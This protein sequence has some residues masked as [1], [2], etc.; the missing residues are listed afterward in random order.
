MQ[1]PII[2][3]VLTVPLDDLTD[4]ETHVQAWECGGE[5]EVEIPE[6][7]LTLRVS[8]EGIK[9]IWH[10]E[11]AAGVLENEAGAALFLSAELLDRIETHR[12][13]LREVEARI[14]AAP[15]APEAEAELPPEP[16]PPKT[17]TS[18]EGLRELHYTTKRALVAA[19]VLTLEE[20]LGKT[21]RDLSTMSGISDA[22]ISAIRRL[23]EEH[24][25]VLRGE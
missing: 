2:Q 4:D 17:E 24:G 6:T 8:R 16:E 22:G 25:R 3:A 9:L 18:I 12:Q 19:G 23:F 11:G 15:P 1:T 20:L 5:E 14:A 10:D 21:L 13:A 7:E